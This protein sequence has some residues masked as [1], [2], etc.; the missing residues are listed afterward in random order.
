MVAS[1]ASVTSVSRATRSKAAPG[2]RAGPRRRQQVDDSE[3]DELESVASYDQSN[4]SIAGTPKL[5]S[6]SVANHENMPLNGS[7]AGEIRS[8]QNSVQNSLRRLTLQ[9]PQRE[10]A[11][12]QTTPKLFD[13]AATPKPSPLGEVSMSRQNVSVVGLNPVQNKLADTITKDDIN[14]V[15]DTTTKEDLPASES[16]RRRLVITHLVL[17]NFKSY[18]GRQEI[19]PFHSV[20]IFRIRN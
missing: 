12:V 10:N 16:P 11:P 14:P 15:V 18:A 7:L 4:K 5:P 1:E 9:S 6:S 19:G 8:P 2:G 3:D 20:R 13:V 17:N